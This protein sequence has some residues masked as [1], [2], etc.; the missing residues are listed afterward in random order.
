VR[1]FNEDKPY[2]DFI[3]EQLA[4]DKIPGIDP[5]DLRL[6]ALGFLTVGERF[7]KNDDIINDRIDTVS[8]GFLALTVACARCHDHMFDPI[9]TRDYYALHGVFSSISEPA[10]KPLI[11]L[12]AT[13][14][15]RQDFEK[16]YAA[17]VKQVG[18]RY[19]DAIGGDLK[20]FFKAPGA[21]IRA[22]C[23]GDKKRAKGSP[24]RKELIK[25]YQLDDEFVQFLSKGMQLNPSV[26]GPLMSF[27]KDGAGKY[28]RVAA[29]VASGTAEKLAERLV[30]KSGGKAD[31]LAKTISDRML[32]G[33]NPL[34]AKAAI[35]V[36]AQLFARM[37]AQAKEFIPAMKNATSQTVPG[38]D[39][40]TIDLLRGPFE[41]VP[42]PFITQDWLETAVRAWPNK[43]ANRARLNFG[44]INLLET[45]HPG[46]P[47]HAMIVQDKAK[48]VNS[49]IFIRGQSQ[50][51]GDVVPRGFLAILSA[52]GKPVEFTEGSGRMELAK[53]IA[54]RDNPLTAR[55]LV[56]RVW[57][58]HFGEG[59]V[60]TPDDLGTMSEKPSHPELLDYLATWFM[61]SGWSLK[62]LHK[63]IVLSRIYQ[64]SSHTRPEYEALDPGNRLI[65]HANVRRLD[66]ESTRDSLLVFSGDLDRTVGGKPINLTEEPYSYRRSVYGYID[67]GNLPELMAQFDFSDPD[68]PN[69]KRSSTVVPQQALFLMNSP[70]A[71]DVA[72]KILAR[73]E[74]SQQ[75]GDLYR[76]GALYRVIFQ[77]SPA[78]HEVQIGL[79]FLQTEARMQR[80]AA[81]ELG[82]KTASAGKPNPANARKDS[83]YRAI[84]NE[85]FAVTRRVLTPWETYV[86]ALLC[87][88]E[89]AYLN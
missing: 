89:A 63:L 13:E 25:Q 18:N 48:P 16:K 62:K 68:M 70:M 8:K 65:W 10:E 83:N 47:A 29:M 38:Y 86:Q 58:H 36:Y 44:D 33:V 53:C 81:A 6:A 35:E 22:A 64:E 56:N 27:Q 26:W 88:N 60:S 17:L 50:V 5:N 51:K 61:D 66:F 42:A 85:G 19:Y 79:R 46:A 84:Q 7:Q 21:Y 78:S 76:I 57:M 24:E 3:I 12:Q 54:S 67:R 28:K 20:D 87:S 71:V 49:P 59:F 41:V 52:G 43:L 34:V 82:P 11:G 2:T 23:T 80:E 45:S 77:R 69:S 75:A 55:V 4:A 9:P 39:A 14:Q 74:V 37:S 73:P 1:S 15:Q 40:A 30:E 72:R 31:K 32:A